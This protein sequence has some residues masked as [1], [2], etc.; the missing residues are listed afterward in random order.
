MVI[1]RAA[2]TQDT[3]IARWDFGTE[4]NTVFESH[5]AVLRDQAGPTP[6]DFTDF[7]ANN[8]AIGF[9][10]SGAHLAIKDSGFESE[11]DFTNG[12]EITLEAWV[13]PD[14]P[15]D[16]SPLYIIGKGRTGNPHFSS[17]NQN[18][19]LRIQRNK[20]EIAISFL[21]ATSLGTGNSHWHRWTSTLTFPNTSH[22][23]HI[24]VA[25]R[26]GEPD[27]ITGW[28]D[29]KPTNGIWDMGGKTTE[30]PVTDDDDIWIGSAR[31]GNRFVGNLDN[32]AIHRVML[33]NEI[34]ASRFHR[35]GA[36]PK[37]TLA[38]ET[39]PALGNIPEN[40]VLLTL[41]EGVP[42][43][44]RWLREGEQWPAVTT[45]FSNSAFLLH[46]LPLRYDTWGIR[47]AW[48]E[49]VLLRMAADVEIQPG[50][51]QFLMR[52]RGMARLWFDG[53]LVC[54]SKP[55][56]Q[57]TPDGEQSVTPLAIPPFPG[58]RSHGYHQQELFFE[59]NIPDKGSADS[60]RVRVVWE[61]IVGGKGQRT[62]TGEICLAIQSTSAESFEVLAPQEPNSIALT[63]MAVESALEH[64]E[65]E[66]AA[67]DD[68]T[69]RTAATSQNTFWQHRHQSAAEWIQANPA[70]AIATSLYAQTHHP[71]DAFIEDK[72]ARA[73]E[74]TTTTDPQI[75]EHFYTR[76][77]PLLSDNCFRCH[78][79]KNKGNLRLNSRENALLAGESELPAVVP[80]EPEASEIISQVRSGA[81]PPTKNTL[82][83]AQIELLS[84]WIRDGAPWPAPPVDGDAVA[85]VPTVDDF[86]FLRRAY[87]DT[88]GV[89]SSSDEIRNF[90]NDTIPDKRSRLIDQ[91]I[92]DERTADHWVSYW[93]DLL[94]E[95]P[96]LL[97]QSIGSTGPFRWF[98]Y[99]SL[100]D[101]KPLDRMVTELILMRG[102][103]DTGG[104]AGFGMSGESDSPLADKASILAGAFL[105][106]DL[107]CARCHDS[108]YHSTTQRDL[109]SLASML[110]RKNI[111]VPATS[112]VPDAFF[113]KK[114]RESLIHVSLLPQETIPP[115]WPFPAIQPNDSETN[116]ASY[117]LDPSDSREQL[118][119]LITSP[120]NRR[121]ARV[122][123]NR[124]W[125]QLIGTGLV[126]PVND[127]EGH[128]PSH[129]A[130]LDW[131]AGELV[132]NQY[133][134]RAVIRLIMTSHVY[135]RQAIGD[136]SNAPPEQRFF[137]APDRRRLTAEQIVDS[138]HKATSSEID[139]EELTFI[140]D[141][142]RTLGSRQTLGCPQ[143]AWMFASLNNERDRPSLSL[144]RARTVTDVMQA[145]GWNGSRQK[146]IN[147]RD[148]EP[149]VL[150]PGILAN[151][152]LVMNL[153]RASLGSEVSEIAKKAVS[154][155]TLVDEWYLRVLGRLP[156]AEERKL[157]SAA[158]S[159]GFQTRLVPENRVVYPQPLP[160]LPLVTWF[161]HLQS[162][163]TIIQ[164]ELERRVR[165]G[166]PVD[167][168]LDPTWRALYEDFLWSLINHREF[169]WIP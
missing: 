7:P 116:F 114:G 103:R 50:Y 32:I 13:R 118:A 91:L 8:T 90:L 18:W 25:Y 167:P 21:F 101:H 77:L 82:S 135:Q 95:N 94:A 65:R 40:Q 78:G 136:N 105:G 22:W 44:D 112:R 131:L 16:G 31:S 60:N 42:A 127:W 132:K 26:F 69:R 58:V 63:N 117:L 129:P 96:T 108:P 67:L 39:M 36:E 110:E 72:I 84:Q 30:P 139:S 6:P 61:I 149:N 49:P 71:I 155:S 81:M 83:E 154:P 20:D 1:A 14:D 157:F 137:A 89:P 52:T 115:Q 34:I 140:H 75:A 150:Q 29:G 4:S 3:A 158:L 125:K 47:D 85:I 124:I 46:R 142:Q 148:S 98:L 41:H 54:R 28:I 37:I 57:K 76:I 23:H 35:V 119:L 45:H 109:Y 68:T 168:K 133:D 128:A 165:A 166:P 10:S 5:G 164:Q 169:V 93:Q 159:D 12:D 160:N 79:E 102:N 51:H 73:V 43:V 147:E 106:I 62:E 55:F 11:F 70:P 161:N 17:D 74:A 163:T 104:S 130:M 145:F 64:L 143:R 138:L 162:E 151:G 92:N 123:V 56:N 152:T 15:S 86:S 113:E 99:E 144:P 134:S 24:A 53:E 100:R 88:V 122:I 146:Q 126:E 121:F 111:Q 153:T 19:A 66:T 33:G 97:N 27:S 120:Q 107:Q 2:H 48:K 59:V 156:T 9:G 38:E 80:G 87:L 141:G